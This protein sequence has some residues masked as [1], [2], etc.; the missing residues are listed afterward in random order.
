MLIVAEGYCQ[1]YATNNPFQKNGPKGFTESKMIGLRKL[2]VRTDLPGVGQVKKICDYQNL[3]AT[4]RH[5]YR[6]S[7]PAYTKPLLISSAIAAR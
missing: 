3:A 6:I 5:K 2:F 1:Y 7:P 4:S